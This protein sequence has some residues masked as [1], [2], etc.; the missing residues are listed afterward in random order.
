MFSQTHAQLDQKPVNVLQI[1]NVHNYIPN[2]AKD[3][4]H[5]YMESLMQC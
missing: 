3:G 2:D 4:L 5:V 1:E